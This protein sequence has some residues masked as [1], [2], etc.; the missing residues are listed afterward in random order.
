MGRIG[1][2]CGLIAAAAIGM[3]SRAPAQVIAVAASDGG[4]AAHWT[5]IKNDGYEQRAHF[6]AGAERL[7]ARLDREI[8]LL[9]A[10]RAAMTKDTKDW[11]FAM[12]EVDDSRS[13]LTSSMS[14]LAKATTPETWGAAKDKVGDAWKRAQAAVDKMNATVTS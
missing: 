4:T 7:S 14:E 9:K 11:D 10:K 1:I 13:Y 5:E 12:K 6:A 8:G 3:V 2:A